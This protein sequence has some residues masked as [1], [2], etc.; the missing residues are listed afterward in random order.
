MEEY[1]KISII[2]DDDTEE[3]ATIEED[4]T[5]ELVTIEDAMGG[6]SNYNFLSNKPKINNVLLEGNKTA[7]ELGLQKEIEVLSNLEIEKI[8]KM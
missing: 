3:L 6:T 1:E 7:K 2:E 4:N 8:L 5:E